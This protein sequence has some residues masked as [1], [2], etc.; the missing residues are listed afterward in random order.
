MQEEDTREFPQ[1]GMSAL[2]VVM[3][4][5]STVGERMGTLSYRRRHRKVDKAVGYQVKNP[6]TSGYEA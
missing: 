1:W 4:D 3:V 6:I 2:A 5:T